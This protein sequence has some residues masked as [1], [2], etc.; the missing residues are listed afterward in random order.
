MAAVPV[1]DRQRHTSTG[2]QPDASSKRPVR[3]GDPLL[4][5]RRLRSA[6]VGSHREQSG[7]L[8]TGPRI[9]VFGALFT[10]L[11]ARLRESYG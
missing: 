5:G 1:N 7:G 8:L 11:D 2:Q 10:S 4:H 9:R 3:A 6:T